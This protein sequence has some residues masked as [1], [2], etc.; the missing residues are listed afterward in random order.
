M[1]KYTLTSY[2]PVELDLPKPQVPASLVDAQIEK[3][4][5]PLAGLGA[6]GEHGVKG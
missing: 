3:L 2:D 1:K 5:E 4:L 6:E